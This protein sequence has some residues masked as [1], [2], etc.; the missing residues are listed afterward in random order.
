MEYTL[1]KIDLLSSDIDFCREHWKWAINHGKALFVVENSK[2]K[3]SIAV[4]TDSRTICSDEGKSIVAYIQNFNISQGIS[5][6]RFLE[7]ESVLS[8]FPAS[9]DY[10]RRLVSRLAQNGTVET[11]IC[12][13]GA[14]KTYGKSSLKQLFLHYKWCAIHR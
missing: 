12:D 4:C 13:C 2:E 10:H 5:V 9:I 6:L 11:T 1:K 8:K 14:V 7:E 3:Y